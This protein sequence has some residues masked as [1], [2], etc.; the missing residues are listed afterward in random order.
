ML[1]RTPFAP[2]ASNAS[3]VA[4]SREAGPS[5][6]SIFALLIVSSIVKRKTRIDKRGGRAI[7]NAFDPR[8]G[9]RIAACGSRA[10]IRD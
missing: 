3:R 9:A 6:A 8:R 7:T 10:T 2:A 1:I 5:V 4:G